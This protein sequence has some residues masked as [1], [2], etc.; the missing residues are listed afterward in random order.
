[1]ARGTGRAPHFQ[2]FGPRVAQPRLPVAGEHALSDNGETQTS[3]TTNEEDVA[4]VIT[5]DC[6]PSLLVQTSGAADPE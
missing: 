2:L 4:S 1:M 5:G 6:P 3:L